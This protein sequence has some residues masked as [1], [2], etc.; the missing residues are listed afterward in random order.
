MVAHGTRRRRRGRGLNHIDKFGIIGRINKH[1]EPPAGDGLSAAVYVAGDDGRT[2]RQRLPQDEAEARAFAGKYEAV[3]QTEP[4]AP[5][6]PFTNAA[7][8]ETP[9]R[10]RPE[11]AAQRES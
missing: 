3:G 9:H 1:A 2:T 6:L 4:R 8:S 11:E 10:E 7:P 5:T